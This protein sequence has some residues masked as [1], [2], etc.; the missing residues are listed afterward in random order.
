LTRAEREASRYDS[1][2]PFVTGH[3]PDY[4]ATLVGNELFENDP[5][6]RR[7][8]LTDRDRDEIAASFN[9]YPSELVG[10]SLLA[11]SS[12]NDYPGAKVGI[13]E[14]ENRNVAADLSITPES[15]WSMSLY[16][17]YDRFLNR[18]RGFARRSG[19]PFYPESVRDP[20]LIWTMRT[21]DRVNSFGAGIDWQ[22][23]G[24][25]LE[26]AVDAVYTDAETETTPG[27]GLPGQGS[28]E[29]SFPDVTTEIS[30]I[31]LQGTYRLQAGREI[32]V[33]YSY[34]DYGSRD[35]ALDNIEA[36]SVSALL[37]LGNKSHRYSGHLLI[38]TLVVDLP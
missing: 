9:V 23:L 3:N 31:A 26:L 6:L 21:E 34:E 16:Y 32:R 25:R 22:L 13:S 10:V 37:L 2:I 20:A 35:W 36:D 7:Y 29:R 4:V 8:H 12:R 18:N 17:N 14:S 38:V 27:S 19:T 1:T 28:D 11:K 24:D 33:R 30:S 15:N 5:L